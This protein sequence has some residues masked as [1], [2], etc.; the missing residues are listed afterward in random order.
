MP[1]IQYQDDKYFR[2]MMLS[3]LI[4]DFI[5]DYGAIGALNRIKSLEEISQSIFQG[6][7]ITGPSQNG[8]YD[9]P[10]KGKSKRGV[11]VDKQRQRRADMKH[12]NDKQTQESTIVLKRLGVTVEDASELS[13]LGIDPTFFNVPD[14]KFTDISEYEY[15]PEIISFLFENVTG[16]DVN[17]YSVDVGQPITRSVTSEHMNMLKTM[18]QNDDAISKSLETNQGITNILQAILIAFSHDNVQMIGL[19]Q[20]IIQYVEHTTF[21][22]M[23]M[24]SN[25]TIEDIKLRRQSLQTGNG[26]TQNGSGGNTIVAGPLTGPNLSY[27]PYEPQTQSVFDVP[28]K[29]VILSPIVPNDNI[30]N[31]LDAIINDTVTNDNL[32]DIKPTEIYEALNMVGDENDKQKVEHL[33]FVNKTVHQIIK[34]TYTFFLKREYTNKYAILNSHYLKQVLMK[35]LL[36]VLYYQRINKYDFITKISTKFVENIGDMLNEMCPLSNKT[37]N[38]VETKKK[39][40]GAI[41]ETTIL[42]VDPSLKTMT[43]KRNQLIKRLNKLESTKQRVPVSTRPARTLKSDVVSKNNGIQ[44]QITAHIIDFNEDV[45]RHSEKQSASDE[46]GKKISPEI[47]SVINLLCSE[48]AYNGLLY[49]GLSDIDSNPLYPDG[50]DNNQ[51]NNTIF[52]N[53]TDILNRI[54]NGIDSVSGIDKKLFD[55]IIDKPELWSNYK[56]STPNDFNAHINN[57]PSSTINNAINKSSYKGIPGIN[58]ILKNAVCSTPQYIDAMGGLGSCTVKQIGNTT[59][60]FPSTIDINIQTGSPNYYSTFIKHNNNRVSLKF[61]YLVDGIKSVP[62]YEQFNLKN[63][64]ELLSASNTMNALSTKIMVLWNTR[65]RLDTTQDSAGIFQDLFKENFNQLISVASRKGKGDRAQEE[66]SVFKNGGYST[67]LNYNPNDIRIGAMG[68]RPS[69]FRA[70]LDMNFLKSDSVRPNT[71]A[72]FFGPNHSYTID[73]SNPSGGGKSSKKRRKTKRKK[74]RAKKYTRRSTKK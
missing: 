60:E 1:V 25:F 71:I 62:Y 72:G 42:P 36:I 40:G 23:G 15:S 48:V 47:K 51:I 17:S 37:Q 39:D 3:L 59:N 26:K 27:E 11:N 54:S 8:G 16:F 33:K 10:Q 44:D 7:I 64:K 43:V 67:V 74:S 38:G 56:K 13:Q 46:S 20:P 21:R 34:G 52:N 63:G 31:V 35:Y 65:Y 19:I 66:N 6:Q 70:M 50:V 29:T 57:R 18:L 68:D 49:M 53:Q 58:G 41:D 22:A 28:K 69:G 12:L 73:S 5:H 45:K 61:D 30:Q 9:P 55:F 4:H 32:R 14:S 2:L 24:Q